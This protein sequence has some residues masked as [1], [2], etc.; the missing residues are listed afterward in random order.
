[1]TPGSDV[2]RASSSTIRTSRACGSTSTPAGVVYLTGTVRSEMERSKAVE[3]AKQTK[4]VRDV[5]PN[6]D[7]KGS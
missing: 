7:I 4:G 3:L 2:G 5:Q 6:L 1:M